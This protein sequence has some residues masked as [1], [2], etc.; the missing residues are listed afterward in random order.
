MSTDWMDSA[1]CATTDPELFLIK[2]GG[3]AVPAKRI[4]RMCPVVAECLQYALDNDIRE[5]I[6]GGLSP[7][8][9]RALRR[10]AA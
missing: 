6:Y 3:T 1:N 5:G 4:C 7:T 2:K 9:R 8:E 10:A